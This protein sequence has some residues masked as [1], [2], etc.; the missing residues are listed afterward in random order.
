MLLYKLLE[1]EITIEVTSP[2]Y[3]SQLKAIVSL[4]KALLKIDF[5]VE[6]IPEHSFDKTKC[7]LEDIIGRKLHDDEARVLKRIIKK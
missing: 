6:E 3:E 5:R 4:K 2:S 7:L 1:M